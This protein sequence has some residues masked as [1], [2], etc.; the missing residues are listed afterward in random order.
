MLEFGVW[1]RIRIW[2]LK[3]KAFVNYLNLRERGFYSVIHSYI[4]LQ[5]YFFPKSCEQ[6]FALLLKGSFV[7]TNEIITIGCYYRVMLGVSLTQD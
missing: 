4:H 5:V 2:R 1:R 3:I 7:G 6:C